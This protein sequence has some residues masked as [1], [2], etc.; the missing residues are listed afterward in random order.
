MIAL[1]LKFT[2]GTND[3]VVVVAAVDRRSNVAIDEFG[4]HMMM[5]Y[6]FVDKY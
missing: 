2:V 3:R 1:L 6:S 4:S 5:Y